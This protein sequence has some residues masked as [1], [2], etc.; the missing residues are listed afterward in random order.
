[1]V[2]VSVAVTALVLTL[3]NKTD[4]RSELEANLELL[5]LT[6]LEEVASSK[7]DNNLIRAPKEQQRSRNW[8][9]TWTKRAKD[10]VLRCQELV[11]CVGLGMSRALQKQNAIPSMNQS[12]KMIQ[13]CLIVKLTYCT[14]QLCI[15]RQQEYH[16]NMKFLL[17][18]SLAFQP[19]RR[20]VLSVPVSLEAFLC[21]LSLL[22]CCRWRFH[23]F[24]LFS[25]TSCSVPWAC[26]SL[27]PDTAP[28]LLHTCS[29]ILS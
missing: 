15:V 9:W 12:I 5:P 29:W 20:A 3:S 11:Q 1:M 21:S 27:L 19:R 18:Q 17:T 13:L 26:L 10:G 24:V 22:H 2:M 8:S 7:F 4:G 23:F 28:V 16:S 14:L 6:T 25:S